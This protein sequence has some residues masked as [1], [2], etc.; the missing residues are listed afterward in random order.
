MNPFKQVY[1]DAINRG[2]GNYSA[3]CDAKILY[4]DYVRLLH[5]EG[6]SDEFILEKLAEYSRKLAEV[7]PK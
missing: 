3:M 2:E 5:G 7:V 6:Y 1:D 4:A